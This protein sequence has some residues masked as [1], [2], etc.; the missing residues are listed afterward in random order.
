[1]L[2]H[3]PDVEITKDRLTDTWETTRDALAPRLS[4][5]RDAATP[6]VDAAAARVSPVLEEART[7][8]RKDVVPAVLA[9]AETAKEGSAPARAEAKERAAGALL[10]LRGENPKKVRR[11]P[12]ALACLLGGAAVGAAA[13]IMRKSATTGGGAAAPT[14]FP[15]AQEPET[16]TPSE[17][18][19]R[20]PSTG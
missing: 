2:R 15:R 17:A 13:S 1:M 5:A 19:P 18:T 12:V 14:P 11:W 7:R 10:A 9:A 6:Y 16:A 3:T 4:A 20:A 8:L